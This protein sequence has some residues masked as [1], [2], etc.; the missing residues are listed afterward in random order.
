MYLEHGCAETHQ[1]TLFSVCWTCS[2]AAVLWLCRDIPH[3]LGV[4][5]VYGRGEA[6]R[7]RPE[8][9]REEGFH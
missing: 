6:V 3:I 8:L 5:S 1:V 2:S 9:Y 4:N 7:S